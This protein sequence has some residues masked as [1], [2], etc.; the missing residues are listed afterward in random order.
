MRECRRVPVERDADAVAGLV[1]DFGAEFFQDVHDLLEIG[2]GAD[3]MGEQR[4]Q[5]LAVVM[6]HV[7]SLGEIGVMMEIIIGRNNRHDVDLDQPKP[8]RNR[9]IQRAIGDPAIARG[10]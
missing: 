1:V 10:A 7:S 3:R 9:R 6:I 2:V 5:D 4:V 8:T